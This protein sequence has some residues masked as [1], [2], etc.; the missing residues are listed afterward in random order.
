[1]LTMKRLLAAALFLCWSVTAHA[2]TGNILVIIADDMGIDMSTMYDTTVR[3]TS[4]SPARALPE[5]TALANQGIK[6]SNFWATPWCSPTRAAV[7][8]GRYGFRLNIGV[9]IDQSTPQVV[10]SL[11]ELTLPEL[12][13]ASPRNY[14]T[15]HIG[16][17]HL[18]EELDSPRDTGWD[19]AVGPHPGAGGPAS[20]TGITNPD[21]FGW[22]KYTNG[23]RAG[24]DTTTYAMT[25][26]VNEAED[27]IAAA[28]TANRPYFIWMGLNSIHSP[29]QEPPGSLYTGADLGSGATN[30]Q[31]VEAMTEAMDTEIG[32][33]LDAVDLAT[34]TVIFLGD[35]G[36]TT[37]VVSSPY[38]S[39]HAKGTIY[40]NGS[41][42]PLII[43]GAGVTQRDGYVTALANA[44]DL[45]PTILELA[46][47]V[48]S[49][50]VPSSTDID[51][52]TLTPYLQNRPHPTPRKWAYAEEFKTGWN[53][54]WERTIRN[55]TFSLIERASGPREFYN[56]VNDPL[57]ATNI[58]SRTLTATEQANLD[59]L[60]E[61]LDDLIATR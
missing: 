2:A 54:D 59:I 19:N 26:Q 49:A 31:I 8:T 6:F 33:L 58:L 35:N 22:R 56:I 55:S 46:G 28:D 48:P 38:L 4:T 53:G 3:R 57:Q 51:G 44:V 13:G 41:H 27:A 12:V 37:G 7:M 42:T 25:D 18:R 60:N 61:Q 30:R 47:L 45:F 52:V 32:R 21:Y 1:M 10:L 34:T 15:T 39:T 11:S 23:T 29:F 43:A 5:L 40:A 20:G 16:K 24:S 14:I 9:P 17:F 36:T 50:V